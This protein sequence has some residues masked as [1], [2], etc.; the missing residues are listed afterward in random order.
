MGR[1]VAVSDIPTFRDF[2]EDGTNGLYFKTRDPHDLAEKVITLLQ[3]KKLREHL[4]RHARE[5]V[6]ERFTNDR[7]I[8]QTEDMYREVLN[9]T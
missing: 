3:D 7:M 8:A 9:V 1:P 5:T 4:G 6:L 2:I